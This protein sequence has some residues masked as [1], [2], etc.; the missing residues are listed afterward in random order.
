[1]TKLLVLQVQYFVGK[2]HS[3]IKV[4]GSNR[5]GASE[6]VAIPKRYRWVEIKH[7]KGDA[8]YEPFN[9]TNL[10]GLAANLPNNYCNV[11]LQVCLL[12]LLLLAIIPQLNTNT[13]DFTGRR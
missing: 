7:S 10:C 2:G 4:A 8:D 13:P 11:M 5:T 1:M 6:I 12:L 9:K 3:K